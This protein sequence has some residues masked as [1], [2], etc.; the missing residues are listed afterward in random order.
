ML[1]LKYNISYKIFNQYHLTN[2]HF[3]SH[4]YLYMN[5]N[6]FLSF[7]HLTSNKS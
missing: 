5:K 1:K 4:M 3:C 2:T 7:C 6:T